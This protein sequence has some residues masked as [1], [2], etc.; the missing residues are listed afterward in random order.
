MESCCDHVDYLCIVHG[1]GV[2]GARG[3]VWSGVHRYDS[4]RNGLV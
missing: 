4:Q 2:Q 1:E 3:G